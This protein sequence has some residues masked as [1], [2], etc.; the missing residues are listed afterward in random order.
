MLDQKYEIEDPNHVGD[1]IVSWIITHACPEKCG[2]CISPQKKKEITSREDHFLLQDRMIKTGLS[3]MR[4]IGGEPLM[5]PH[6]TDLVKD[7]HDR[8]LNTRLS[9]NGILLTEDKFKELKNSLNSVAL[10]FE[11][12]D[13]DLNQRIRC[14]KNHRD[15]VASRIKMIKDCDKNIGLIINTCVHKEN[16]DKLEE[17]GYLL[18]ELHVD[19]WKLRKFSSASGRGAVPNKN[20]FEITDQ[21]FALKVE[22]LQ[23]MYPNLKIDGRMPKKL[24]TRLMVSPQGDL[25]RMIGSENKVYGNMLRDNLNLKA[26]SQRDRC[27]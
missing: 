26:I 18:N 10:P 25:Y 5:V 16:I 2:Y 23:K 3:K 11:S 21:E 20:R 12:L 4:Y 15:V 27:N 6:L 24:E 17:L 19:H 7:A 8:G 1:V 22:K 9:T 14:S 13:D